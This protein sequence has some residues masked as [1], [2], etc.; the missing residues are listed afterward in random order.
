MRLT[1]STRF[2]F[3]AAYFANAAEGT[4]TMLPVETKVTTLVSASP[5]T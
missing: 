3:A 1:S 5:P 4:V 2:P